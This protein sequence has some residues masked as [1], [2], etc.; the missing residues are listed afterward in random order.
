MLA[1]I[2]NA[3][4]LSGITPVQRLFSPRELEYRAAFLDNSDSIALSTFV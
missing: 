2:E 4:K 3:P 1:G